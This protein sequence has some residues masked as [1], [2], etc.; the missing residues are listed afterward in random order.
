MVFKPN[1][2][3]ANDILSDSQ[4][5]LLGNFQQLDTSFGIDHF[6][7]SDQTADNGF[8][9]KVT[10]PGNVAAPTPGAGYG[11]IYAVTTASI[12]QPYWIRDA[13]ATIYNMLPIKAFGSFTGAGAT[14]NASNLTASRTAGQPVGVFDINIAANV[15]NPVPGTSYG[16]LIGTGVNTLNSRRIAVY[17]IVSNILT[18]IS[19]RDAVT[20]ALLDP[21]AFTVT[22]LQA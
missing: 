6:P 21:D 16:V 4:G 7:F 15:I 11:D 18:Q 5:D 17:L 19:F 10:L 3:Q 22:I 13:Q 1:I 20:N 8:H 2:P 14:I 12:T 9:K